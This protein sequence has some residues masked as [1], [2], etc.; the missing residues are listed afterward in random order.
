MDADQKVYPPGAHYS[1]RNRIPNIQQFMDSLDQDKKHRDAKIDGEQ[2]NKV[3]K[4]VDAGESK[5]HIQST[6]RGK[7]HR[8]VRDPVTGQDIEIADID[9]SFVKAAKNPM[10]IPLPL[11]TRLLV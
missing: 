4:A 3:G 2:T 1:G 6:R 9:S 10:V 5:D 8:E 7:N 11:P